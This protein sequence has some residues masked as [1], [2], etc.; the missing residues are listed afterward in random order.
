MGLHS[1]CNWDCPYCV[2]KDPNAIIDED[3]ILKQ[4]YPIRNRLGR[5]ELSGGEPGLLSNSFW[6]KLTSMTQHKL[7]ICTNGTF[8]HNDYHIKFEKDIRSILI[9]CVEELD[10][11]IHQKILNIHNT[12]TP[13]IVKLNIVV[14]N[15]NHHLL[16]NFLEKYKG[17]QFTI[18]FTDSTFTPFHHNNPYDYPLNKDSVIS[19]IKTLSK[20]NYMTYT[21]RLM[22]MIIKDDYRY[23]NTW[24]SQNHEWVD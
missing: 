8:I 7:A 6:S 13:Y 9:H 1:K 14:H 19:V 12:S 2:S 3:E 22:R 16:Y 18:F 20:F 10:Q 23:L 11:D 17:I 21:N 24:S 5:L 4:I 15:K